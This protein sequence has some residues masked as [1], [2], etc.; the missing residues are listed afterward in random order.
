[1]RIGFDATSAVSQGQSM[2]KPLAGHP[3]EQIGVK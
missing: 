1:M 2:R 3:Y